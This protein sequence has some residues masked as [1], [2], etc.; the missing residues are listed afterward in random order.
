MTPYTSG[1]RPNRQERITMPTTRPA[2]TVPPGARFLARRMREVFAPYP[3]ALAG[4]AE[5]VHDLRV[6]SRR[7]RVA[8]PLLASDAG[9]KR[10]R[11]AERLLRDLAR[12]AGLCRALDVGAELVAGLAPRGEGSGAAGG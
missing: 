5:A 2:P 6:A 8:L 1:A 9:A 4:N 7:L 12:A 10:A 11:R 3:K